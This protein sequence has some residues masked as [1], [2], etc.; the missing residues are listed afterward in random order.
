[1]E[2]QKEQNWEYWI[3][4]SIKELIVLMMNLNSYFYY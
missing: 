2:L 3:E 1:M 4:Y